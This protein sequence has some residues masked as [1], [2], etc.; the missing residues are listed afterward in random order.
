MRV[1]IYSRVSTFD[2]GQ[3]NHNQLI[4]LREFCRV[5]GWP[6]IAEYTDEQ[7]GKDTKRP[8]YKAMMVAGLQR[9]YDMVLFWALDRFS[10][11]GVLETLQ[12]LEQLTKAGIEWKS[13]KEQYLDSV[14]PFKDAIIAILATVAKQ[15]RIRLVERTRAGL[16][17]AA[18]LGK[19]SG[20][21]PVSEM[22]ALEIMGLRA[23]GKSM[24]VIAA[25]LGIAP[26]TVMK[27]VKRSRG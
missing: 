5:Q 18:L 26:S 23:A 16:A 24:R 20:R 8:G 9:K 17:K 4:D 21:R 7:S 14:G 13:Y 1:A 3:D 25:E 11:G 6:I 22:Q 2:T 12:Q 19:V 27:V 15:E 10:R